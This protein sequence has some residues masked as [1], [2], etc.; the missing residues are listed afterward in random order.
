[1]IIHGI[2]ASSYPPISANILA[3]RSNASNVSATS[4]DGIT[5]TSRTMPS[6][7]DWFA[8]QY[9]NGVFFVVGQNTT[10]GAYSADGITW[11]TTTMPASKAWNQTAYGNST[12]VVCG[13]NDPSY[14][15]Y[16]SDLSSWSN[17]SA[18]G[19]VG[20]GGIAFGAGVFVWPDTAGNAGLNAYYSSNGASWTNGGSLG[21]A[22]G[23]TR[24]F[25]GANGGFIVTNNVSN[26]YVS[27]ST[28]GTGSW[29]L[30]TLPTTQSWQSCLAYGNGTW[31]YLS[32]SST[33]AASSTDGINWTSRTAPA[34]VSWQSMKYSAKISKFIAVASGTST[35]AYSTTGTGS[36]TTS[37]MPSSG[38]W[39]SISSDD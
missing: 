38:D 24:V 19:G 9:A 7:Q 16:S 36:W 8:L 15:A 22:T 37:T 10:N 33:T 14:F 5:W 18:G 11:T 3:I 25:Y 28:S 12:W 27:Q 17:S 31:S 26:S 21:A 13:Q 39:R 30:R 29:S 4:K 1:M 2:L 34:S 35:Y 6:S 20:G 23:W 32:P